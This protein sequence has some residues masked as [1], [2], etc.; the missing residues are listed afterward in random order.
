M[1]GYGIYIWSCYGLA[2]IL[3]LGNLWHVRCQKQRIYK[4]LRLGFEDLKSSHSR[5]SSFDA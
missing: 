2:I 5:E 4:T 3:F 1:G